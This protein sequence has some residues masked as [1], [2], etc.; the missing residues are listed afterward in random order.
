MNIKPIGSEKKEGDLI[1]IKTPQYKWKYKHNYIWEEFHKKNIPKGYCIIFKDNN[2]ANFAIENLECI[3]V[4]KKR[5]DSVT[6]RE[7]G[8]ERKTKNYT[9]IKLFD[10]TWKHKHRHIW[11]EFHKKPVPEGHYVIFKDNN[12][13]NFAIEN[14]ICIT[15]KEFFRRRAI[16][17]ALDEGSEQQHSNHLLVKL[18]NNKWVY[19]HR[20]IWEEFHKKIVPKGHYIIF[21]DN[22]YQNFAIDNL[23]CIKNT[24]FLQTRFQA[25]IQARGYNESQKNGYALVKLA[26][27]KWVYKHRHIWEEFHKKTVSGR[28]VIIFLDGDR[29]N[30]AI[31]NLACITRNEL[32]Y[33]SHHN[34]VFSDAKLSAAGILLAKIKIALI[35]QKKNSK[36]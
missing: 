13:Q 30:F 32:T 23:L 12:Q 14:L 20:H 36:E 7:I 4:A 9:L 15:Q 22:D 35:K 34:L 16:A 29:T 26:N 33:V 31:E 25:Y 10:G 3:S 8:A 27:S 2:L 1:I 24:E 11:E 21:K 18:S 19:K 6:K 28:D 17:M 5:K